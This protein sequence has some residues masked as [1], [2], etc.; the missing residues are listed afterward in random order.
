MKNWTGIILFLT[1]LL[2]I[3]CEANEIGSEIQPVEDKVSVKT[4]SFHVS[5]VSELV[6]KRYSESDK[7]LLGSYNDPIYGS[8]KFDFLSEFRYMNS[9]YPSSAK[10]KSIQVVL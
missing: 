1:S 3:A 2:L 6:S 7:L 4:D 10:A 9:S 8:S 5:A